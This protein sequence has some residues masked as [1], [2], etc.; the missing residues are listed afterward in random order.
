MT[1]LESCLPR[2]NCSW[3]RDGH[4]VHE[5]SLGKGCP[6][7]PF[8]T[9]GHVTIWA[10]QSSSTAKYSCKRGFTLVGESSRICEQ[11]GVWQ[12]VAPKCKGKLSVNPSFHELTNGHTKVVDRKAH[13]L[14]SWL[15]C[16]LTK[17]MLTALF[18]ASLCCDSK[19]WLSSL[20][21][22]AYERIGHGDWVRKS[23]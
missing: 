13:N 10:G 11:G 1:Q 3:M 8:I 23:V 16:L 4:L 19:Y 21:V 17:K 2:E 20:H 14:S 15:N 18:C 5:F 7:L 12:G 22:V 6:D 9:N